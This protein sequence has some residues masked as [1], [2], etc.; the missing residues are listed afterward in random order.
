MPK[1]EH[2]CHQCTDLGEHE[3]HDLYH[4]MQGGNLA[5]VLARY[6]NEGSEYMSGLGLSLAPLVEA[7]QRATERGL[8]VEWRMSE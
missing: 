5:T 6:G 1:Y 8:P 4:C 7:E 2:D 3:G